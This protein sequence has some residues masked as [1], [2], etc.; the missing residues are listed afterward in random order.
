MTVIEF[1]N[2]HRLTLKT[3]RGDGTQVVVGR[4]GQIYEY[5]ATELAVMFILLDDS[6]PCPRR[7]SN[8][9]RKCA[10]AGMRVLQNGDAEGTLAFDPSNPE[11][12][13]LAIA[14]AGIK[15]KKKLSDQHRAKLV[16]SGVRF[17]RKPRRVYKA[18]PASRNASCESGRALGPS[19]P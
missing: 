7:W 1:A 8:A 3:D 15:R 17:S 4:T 6:Q 14:V 9:L 12:V 2:A 19:H 11:Q 5:S 13:K 16:A 18:A 10:A